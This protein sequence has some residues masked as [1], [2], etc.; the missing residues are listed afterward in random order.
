M[1]PSQTNSFGSIEMSKEEL[2]GLSK[3]IKPFHSKGVDDIDPT[4]ALPSL[5]HIIQP[6]ME[7]IN[8]SFKPGIFSQALKIAKVV[9]IFK[10]GSR[11]E[12]S[13]YRP[14]SV[15]PFFSKPFEKAMH[16]RLNNYIDRTRILFPSQ[17]GFQTEHST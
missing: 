16:E 17:H 1:S 11:E 10:K 15:L 3:T 2:L 14:V 12:V 4:I 7:I 9:P 6:I 13:N 5:P 8:C